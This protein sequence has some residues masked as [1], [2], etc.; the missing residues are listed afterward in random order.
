VFNNPVDF[1]KVA[2]GITAVGSYFPTEVVA[3]DYFSGYL[4]T[5]EAWILERTGIRERRRASPE[6]ASSDLAFE[7]ARGA[8]AMRGIVP[9]ELDCIIVAT[10]TP[11]MLFPAT[12]CLLQK[13]L[14]AFGAFCFDLNA[15]CSGFLYALH[16]AVSLI[17]SG[18]QHR[19]LLVG[20]DTMSS[21][22]DYQDRSTCVLFGDGAG[23]VVVEALENPELGVLDTLL[24][25]DGRGGEYLFLPAGGSRKPASPETVQEGEHYIRQ[26]GKQ[27][28][29]HA[30]PE[31]AKVSLEVLERNGLTVAELDLFVPHQANLRIIEACAR[32]MGLPLTKAFVNIDRYGNTTNA[33]IPSCLHEAYRE[34]RLHRGSLV[35]LTTFGAGFAW[36]STLLRWAIE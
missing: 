24:R 32:E 7:A 19:I 12:A 16:V 8:L 22:L 28:F 30:Y 11:D 29:R 2:V 33:T 20:V 1:S 34:G 27:V 17:R 13:R 4:D 25:S 9:A 36:G 23:A 6:Q 31:M 15:A 3:N 18:A 35:Q 21:I 26:F 10:V 14:E 5:S